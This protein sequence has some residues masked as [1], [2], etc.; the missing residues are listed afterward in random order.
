[1]RARI[2]LMKSMRIILF[3]R[4]KKPRRVVPRRGL[5]VRVLKVRGFELNSDSY[6]DDGLALGCNPNNYVP[7]HR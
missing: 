2:A 1:M 5:V 6:D 4:I 7:R 3:M